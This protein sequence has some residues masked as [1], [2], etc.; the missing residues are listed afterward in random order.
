LGFSSTALAQPEDGPLRGSVE[1]TPGKG[2]V[3]VA[4]ETFRAGEAA[5][6]RGDFEAAA[7]SFEVSHRLAPHPFALFNSGLA[8]Q[9]AGKPERAADAFATALELGG[10]NEMQTAD[11]EQRLAELRKNLGW[12]RIDAPADA[13]LTF[14]HVTGAKAP[15]RVH[16]TPGEHELAVSYPDGH[17][18]Q[19]AVH[20]QAGEQTDVRVEARPAKPPAKAPAPIA[21]PSPAAPPDGGALVVGGW[22]GVGLAVLAGGAAIGMGVAA[23]KGRDDFEAS[24]NTDA[25]AHDRAATLRITTNVAWGV[26]GAAAVAGTIMLI[27]G[28]GDDGSET[29]LLVSPTSLGVRGR[30]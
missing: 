3:V 11:A 5:Y 28:Y 22:V 26:A 6:Q 30:F 8:W 9:A 29:G 14:G 13:S 15:T 18:E 10:L 21:S 16:L 7:H 20:V 25:S 19:V 27:V 17:S 24:G 4:A 23:L 1:P 2:D 12:A